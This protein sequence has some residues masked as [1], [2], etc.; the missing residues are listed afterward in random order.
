[1]GQDRGAGV[2]THSGA[3]QAADGPPD[4]PWVAKV[5]RAAGHALASP[6]SQAQGAASIP[7][8]EGVANVLSAF[9]VAWS[10]E[11]WTHTGEAGSTV[12][13][14]TATRRAYQG[15]PRMHGKDGA[16]L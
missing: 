15:L 13:V 12:F 2:V 14:D 10:R 4:D 5:A 8:D 3:S 11:F 9:T 1:V 16:D 7:D 6:R